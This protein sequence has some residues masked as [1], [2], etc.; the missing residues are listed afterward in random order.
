MSYFPGNGSGWSVPANYRSQQVTHRT[1]SSS[2]TRPSSSIVRDIL[3]LFLALLINV[4]FFVGGVAA[5][6]LAIVILGG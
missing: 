2:P 5:V 3:E 6:W 1:A 4:A